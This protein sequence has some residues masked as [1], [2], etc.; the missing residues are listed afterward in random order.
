[1]AH[2]KDIKGTTPTFTIAFYDASGAVINPSTAYDK[3]E[4]LLYNVASDTLIV[5]FSTETPGEGDDWEE[6]TPTATE[7]DVI[8]PEE[9]TLAAES[10]DNRIEVWTETALGVI[11]CSTAI[12]NEFIDAKNA[13]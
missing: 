13:I 12:F 11:D 5:K 7:V 2:V 8:F 9:I 3:I 10:G 6:I 4:V 1:M